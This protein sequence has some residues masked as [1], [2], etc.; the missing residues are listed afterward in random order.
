MLQEIREG[1]RGCCLI[2]QAGTG[3]FLRSCLSVLE[4]SSVKR[5]S[6]CLSTQRGRSS[7]A[8]SRTVLQRG[9]SRDRE[10]MGA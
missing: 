9:F 5:W 10:G 1:C 4:E 6:C 3:S 2:F 8:G 7:R